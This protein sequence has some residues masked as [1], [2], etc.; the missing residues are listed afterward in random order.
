MTEQ[1]KLGRTAKDV[2]RRAKAIFK[3]DASSKENGEAL[4]S[5]M[6]PQQYSYFLAMSKALQD[7]KS[8]ESGSQLDAGGKP[9]LGRDSSPDGIRQRLIN[10][11][12]AERP[13]R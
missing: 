11:A 12:I 13:R 8:A 4:R 10:A 6:N 5:V 1:E 7:E 2:I 3:Q 9:D